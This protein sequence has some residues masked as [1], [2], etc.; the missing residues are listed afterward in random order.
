MEQQIFTYPELHI[1]LPQ[2]G[3]TSEV[4]LHIAIPINI[5]MAVIAPNPR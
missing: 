2:K 5:T 1:K 3:I 4:I